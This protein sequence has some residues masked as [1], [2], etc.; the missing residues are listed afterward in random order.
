MIREETD[1]ALVNRISNMAEVL[2]YIARHGHEVDWSPAIGHPDCIIASNGEDACIVF[3]RNPGTRDWQC[4]TIF[5]PTCRGKRAVETGRSI[6]DYML[7]NHADTIFGSIP[8]AF[9]HALW[10]Y[11]KMGGIQIPEIES[12]GET[13]VAQENETLFA[14]R[15]ES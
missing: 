14:F 5:A 11:R 12:G 9:K 4:T 6:G 8:N 13:Y 15:K 2:P 3:E 1:A 7:A 10:F